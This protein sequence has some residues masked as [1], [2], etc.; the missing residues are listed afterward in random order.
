[1]SAKP[2]RLLGWLVLVNLPVG[3]AQAFTN[4]SFE[5]GLG[6]W[7]VTGAEQAE[8][9]A[10]QVLQ[11]MLQASDGTRVL[12]LS[13]GPAGRST[14]AV[15]IDT[16]AISE[17][18]LSTVSNTTIHASGM[19][20][21]EFDWA[22]A[23]SELRDELAF[24]DVFEVTLNERRI[25]SG[26]APKLRAVSTFPDAPPATAE[27]LQ[28][29]TSGAVHGTQLSRGIPPWQRLCAPLHTQVGELLT[30]K[31]QI[32]D[33]GDNQ[34]DS[35][36][37]IDRVQLVSECS[38]DNHL[39][40]QQLTHAEGSVA[41]AKNGDII[42]RFSQSRLPSASRDGQ[43]VLFISSSDLGENPALL[44]QVYEYRNG[45]IRRITPWTGDD[46]HSLNVSA[47]GEYAVISARASVDDNR[48]IYRVRFLDGGAIGRL[49]AITNTQD[50][51]NTQPSVSDD[52]QHI[53]FLS[54]CGDGIASGFNLDRSRELVY[55][56]NGEFTLRETTACNNF[57]PQL[58]A[59]NGRRYVLVAA[60]C[61]FTQENH[62][63]NIEVF[64]FTHE[65]DAYT[66][67]LQITQTTNFS[68]LDSVAQSLDGQ[69]SYFVRL[70]ALGNF[71]IHRY[72]HGLGV[73]EPLGVSR[74]DRVPINLQLAG[75]GEHLHIAY[76]SLDLLAPPTTPCLGL[77]VLNPAS[78]LVNEALS[79]QHLLGFAAAADAQGNV[80]LFFSS[81]SDLLGTNDDGNLELFSGL[82]TP[83]MQ[84]AKVRNAP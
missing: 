59:A 74:F 19:A 64:R 23:S 47:N 78:Q 16:N 81:A 9:V 22:F 55:W 53:V 39:R 48:E 65:G 11:G 14:E 61:N 82:I 41:V 77:S 66:E 24:D 50:C 72:H 70:D 69:E 27:A 2:W 29:L 44:E 30:L 62:D 49:E 43:R 38:A 6:S 7:Q 46:V 15:S 4:G 33:Q 79:G 42:V 68:V 80:R 12:V 83:T 73:T 18:D 76:E 40:L 25:L 26:S 52:G 37:F 36:L 3:W 67:T 17:F 58:T 75:E 34:T 45:A 21:L 5:Q 35:A 8:S 63:A 31:I 84:P 1:M 56:H 32:A 51:D 10:E 54:T 13:T 57:N 28:L 60:N 71:A 20:Y